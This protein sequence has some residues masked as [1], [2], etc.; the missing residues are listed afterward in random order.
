MAP[1]LITDDELEDAFDESLLVHARRV[2][3]LRST[4]EGR[5]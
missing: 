1:I 5:R 4:S 3:Q 2:E